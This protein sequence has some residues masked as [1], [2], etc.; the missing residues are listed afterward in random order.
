MNI[1]SIADRPA[2]S[3]AADGRTLHPV[4]RGELERRWLLVR[5]AMAGAGVDALV[6]QGANGISGGGHFRWLAGQPPGNYNPRTLI[7][8]AEGLMTLVDQGP[9]DAVLEFDGNDAAN[10]G[11]GRRCMVPSYPSVVYTAD[12]DAQIVVREIRRHGYR[13]IGIVAAA[14]SYYAFGAGL[15]EQL[16]AGACIDMTDAVDAIKAIKSPEEIALIQ[17]AADMQDRIVVEV[18]AAIRPGMRDFEVMAHAQHVGQLLGSEQGMFFGSSAAPGQAAGLRPRFQQG[19][20]LRE[21]DVFTLLVENSGPGG[22]FAH[23]ARPLVLGRATNELS[24]AFEAVCEAQ[25]ATLAM[26]EPGASC[27]EVFAAYN[28]FMRAR[29]WPEERRLHCHGQG[30]DLVERPLIRQD[31][32]LRIEAGMNIAAHPAIGSPA[33]FTTVCENYLI[34][35]EGPPRC[36][37]RTPQRIIEL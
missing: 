2:I 23:I 9:F 34:Q 27:A 32:T 26:L 36:F 28:A 6:V 30:Y 17:A 11:V 1:L 12:Y 35:P 10:P 19:R 3:V 8:P 37:H 13:R 7:F 21:G 5:R 15:R 25:R 20:E 22:M 4:S 33:L 31:E 29:G 18:A 16:G 14:S 24:D